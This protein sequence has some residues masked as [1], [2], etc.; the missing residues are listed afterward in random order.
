MLPPHLHIFKNIPLNING[1]RILLILLFVATAAVLAALWHYDPATSPLAPKCPFRLLTG[2]SCPACGTQRALHALLH[3]EVAAALRFNPFMV[4][5]VPYALGLLFT[6]YAA[7]GEWAR[8]WYRR[9]AGRVAVW[10]YVM[11]FCTWWIV[12]N[13]GGW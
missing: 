8:R 9:L 10:A 3:G 6:K 11:F 4:Y 7:R 1:R 13:I 2:L 12:R 5:S